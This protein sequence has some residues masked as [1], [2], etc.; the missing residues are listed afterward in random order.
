MS[1]QASQLSRSVTALVIFLLAAGVA[2]LAMGLGMLVS[3]WFF[4]ILIGLILLPLLM[5]AVVVKL[6]TPMSG[7]DE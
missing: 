2:A 4:L 3:P 5:Y 6:T 1:Q 7:A